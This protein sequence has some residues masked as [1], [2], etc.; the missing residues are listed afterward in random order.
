VDYL[1][2]NKRTVKDVY[3]ISRMGDCL[4]SL[5]DATVFSTLECNDRYLQIPV[6]AEDR[7][8]TTFTSHTGLFRFLRL[9]F[10]LLN[11]PAS[12]QRKL[13]II[14]SGLWW[15]TCP[16]YLDDGIVFF[17]TV[18][19]HIRHLRKVLLLL[20]KSGVSLKP[21]KC[22]LF[23]QEFEYLGHV[24]RPGELLVNQKSLKSMAQALPPRNQTE[25]KS[26]LSMCNVYGRFIK[27]YA[28][29]A[30][31]LTKLTSKKLRHVLPSLVAAQLA[32][33]EFLKDRL[34]STPILALPRR[35]GLFIL[36]TDAC[37]FQVG[38]TLLQQQTDASI[39]PFGYYSRDVIPA[40]KF[41]S[42]TDR[43]CLAV[44]WTCF[45]H[46]PYLEGQEFLI[47]TDH[48]SSHW[49]LSMDRAQGRVARWR[50]RLSE[51]RYKVCTRP[52][53]EHHGA[54]AMSLLPTLAPDRSVIPEEIPCL[55]LAVS[56]LV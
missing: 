31:P 10:G 17:W 22:H 6:A 48:S 25:L 2:L 9:P 43:D 1:P 44:V 37:A 56:F 18:D 14:W 46:S 24:V 49:M 13:D 19:E 40:A 54:D 45:F 7:D 21:S 28:H 30:K 32:A 16:V 50:L 8:M 23:Q 11:A 53:R 51:F 33:F 35:E 29:I 55:A 39:L 27:N 3:P 52:G 34:T 26:F 38:C 5:G 36:D 4:D 20:E 12:F 47:R 42:T 41:Y 15:Q